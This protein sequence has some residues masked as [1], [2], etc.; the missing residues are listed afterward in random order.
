[1]INY[2]ND[3]KAMIKIKNIGDEQYKKLTNQS[4]KSL[5]KL[6]SITRP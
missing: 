4:P 6:I 3:I 2:I 1:M 5:I